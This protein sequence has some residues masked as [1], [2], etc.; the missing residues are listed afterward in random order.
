MKANYIFTIVI[1]SF[2]LASCSKQM[3]LAD[4]DVSYTTID[5]NVKPGDEEIE[6][7]IAPYK[8][9]L[10]SIMNSVIAYTDVELNKGRPNSLL[11]QWF[12]D[13]FS[14]GVY[15]YLGDT[16]I[17][18]FQNY[19]GIRLNSIAPG[20]ISV[21]TVY[22]LMPFD[23][24]LVILD[25]DSTTLQRFYDKIA[26]KGGWPISGTQFTLTAE[27]ARDIII[28]GQALT[29]SKNY[30]LALPDYIANG[31]DDC[32]FLRDLPRIPTDILI[33]DLIIN[34]LRNKSDNLS[35]YAPV[36]EKRIKTSNHE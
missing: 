15:N 2:L 35:R 11:G 25:I 14:E 6:D 8:E 7:L 16:T 22:E 36:L 33:R 21:G 31:G 27:G 24:Q 5:G 29:G 9:G 20:P 4:T 30:Q 34:T 32:D 10:D 12:I 17:A 3:Y 1:A 19:G 28:N 26:E 23:N 18:C 13:V